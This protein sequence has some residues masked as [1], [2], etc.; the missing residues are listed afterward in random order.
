M[1]YKHRPGISRGG[2]PEQNVTITSKTGN[3]RQW[4]WF[5]FIMYAFVIGIGVWHHEPWRDE[6]QSWLLT[7]D[8]SIGQLLHILPTEGHPPLWYFLI[9]PL[10]KLGLPYASQNWLAALLMLGAVYILLFRTQL[11][12]AIKVLLPCSYLFIYEYTC[13]ARSYCLIPFFISCLISLHNDRFDKPWL[14]TLCLIGLFNTHVLVFPLAFMLL[15]L[16]I[17]D[18]TKENKWSKAT[19]AANIIAAVGG[20]Y[21]I[22]YLAMSST[23]H[24]F[25]QRGDWQYFEKAVTNTI[26]IEGNFLLAAALVIAAFAVLLTRPKVFLL[27]LVSMLLTMYILMFK[28]EGSLRHHGILFLELFTG[29]ALLPHYENDKWRLRMKSNILFRKGY[30]LLYLVILL[31]L[32]ETIA[33]YQQDI[34]EPYSNA[35][36]AAEY[37]QQ[38]ELENKVI[39]A[40]QA[41]AGGAL[42]PYLPKGKK[43]YY[44]EKQA[45]GSYYTYDSFFFQKTWLLEPG[46]AMDA[47]YR[48]F[49]KNLDSVI[50][51]L[52]APLPAQALQFVDL[53][54]NSDYRAIETS[55]N[56]YIYQFKGGVK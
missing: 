1:G 50:I 5:V 35:K 8:L 55:E 43:M 31:Q 23:A 44:P 49:S 9:M 26:L 10:S 20:G 2:K 4:L 22:P 46:F 29:F 21:L 38:Y 28:Y 54:Y 13:F 15:C 11:S 36:E 30:Y 56:Y 18:I 48:K 51:L 34:L 12:I 24:K 19:V 47:T 52:N 6:A 17:I 42:L 14:Y 25:I 3:N 37:I 39:V 7:R 45:F 16:Y 40:H 32:P 33:S 27:V 41:W 53:L